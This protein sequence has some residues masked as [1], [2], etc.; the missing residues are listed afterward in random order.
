MTDTK[1]KIGKGAA[2]G[3][4]VLAAVAG[5]YYLYSKF[6]D[7]QK[8]KVKSWAFRLRADVLDELE[9]MKDVSQKAY[10]DAVD[11]ASTKYAKLKNVD[12]D[13]LKLL[14]KEMKKHWGGIQKTV[15]SRT[16]KVFKDNS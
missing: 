10:D 12:T 3:T 8:S 13:E 5:S 9:N 11:V 6:D 15:A 14:A 4:A 2:M 16:R 1:S 7:K